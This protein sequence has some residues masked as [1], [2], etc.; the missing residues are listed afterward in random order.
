MLFV[1]NPFSGYKLGGRLGELLQ[2]Y[3]NTEIY[4][5]Q[6]S[7][8]EYPGHATILANQ[9]VKDGY[10]AVIAAGGDGTVNEVANALQGSNTALGIIPL[11]SGNGFAYHLNIRRDFNKAIDIINQAHITT[12]DTGSVNGRFFVNVAG[13]GLDAAVAFKTKTNKKRGFLPYLKQ[14]LIEGLKFKKLHLQISTAGK[15]WSGD[16][17]MAVIANGSIYGYNFAIAP[18]AILDDG[19]FDVL[20]VK[21]IPLWKY[22]FLLP[23][24]ITKTI[25][26]SPYV[27][28][29]KTNEIT[30]ITDIDSYYHVDGE[31]FEIKGSVHFKNQ[32]QNLKIISLPVN[33]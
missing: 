21:Y 23:R 15:S 3:L 2:K 14:S 25:Q 20:L 7:Y 28:Y 9:A 33:L 10:F 19:V 17:A 29:F 24:F 13:M 12:I 27:E 5:Y 31:G 6:L 32:P 30:L 1:A 18:S 16:Y 11:G 22:V 4:E 26:N 8:T